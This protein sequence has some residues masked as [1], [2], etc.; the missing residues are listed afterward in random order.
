MSLGV[1]V[2]AIR[3]RDE[4]RDVSGGVV[5]S[6]S[7]ATSG[8]RASEWRAGRTIEAPVTFRRRARYLND[9]VPD[10]ERDLAL[11][12]TTLLGTVKSALLVEVVERG[13]WLD[14]LAA[15]SRARIRRA[16]ER[17]VGA[18]QSHV[19]GAGDRRAD[20]RPCRDSGRRPRTAAGLGHLPRHRHLRRQHR[21]LRRPR[22]GSVPRSGSGSSRRGGADA[23]RAARVRGRRGV[24]AIC[25]PGGDGGRAVSRRP[26]GRSPRP[27]VAGGRDGVRRAA[28]R[29]A[30]RSAGCR[31]RADLRC[32]VRAAGAGQRDAAVGR[33]GA[34]ALARCSRSA[35]RWP[36]KPCCCRCRR[37]SSRRCRWPASC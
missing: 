24:G 14:E 17:W 26:R 4:W 6:V 10:F 12:G 16:V 36:S 1:D 32:R 28:G 11:D 3:V 15:A 7:G 20:R 5:L 22:V 13:T 35:R 21:G 27:G 37:S 19:R 9:G 18:A 23:R 33:A 25:P 31:L 29:V 34:G 30:A 8:E 2:L